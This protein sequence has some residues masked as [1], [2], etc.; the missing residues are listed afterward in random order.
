MVPGGPRARHVVVDNPRSGAVSLRTTAADT[1]G[2]RVEQTV[3][4]AYLIDS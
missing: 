1:A 2:N 4:R 3:I